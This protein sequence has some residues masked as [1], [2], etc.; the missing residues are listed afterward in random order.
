MSSA[1][2]PRSVATVLPLTC[3]SCVSK[4]KSRLMPIGVSPVCHFENAAGFYAAASVKLG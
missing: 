4:L 3:T 2:M 1:Q